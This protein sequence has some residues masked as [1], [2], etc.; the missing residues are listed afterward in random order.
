MSF[1]ILFTSDCNGFEYKDPK[2]IL[3]TVEKKLTKR[4]ISKAEIGNRF[5]GGKFDSTLNAMGVKWKKMST[6]KKES[7]FK[8]KDY[9]LK[10]ELFSGNY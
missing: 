7:D 5:V 3:I 2:A 10:F 9:D 4:K 8:K 1:K 6:W